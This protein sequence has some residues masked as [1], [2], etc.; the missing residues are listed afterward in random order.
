MYIIHANNVQ[1]ENSVE[2]IVSTCIHHHHQDLV[3]STTS[4]H[5]RPSL[6]R[7]CWCHHYGNLQWFPTSCLWGSVVHTQTMVSVHDY[8]SHENIIV[9]FI[10]ETRETGSWY[11][12]QSRFKLSPKLAM[13]R[14][15]KR[16]FPRA[17]R[18]LPE[19]INTVLQPYS[20]SHYISI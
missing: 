13:L 6:R 8:M 19:L 14:Q 5:L 10:K 16:R 9:S 20:H 3:D 12:H 17:S 4:L 7:K 15:N 1:V 18:D 11:H 2:V